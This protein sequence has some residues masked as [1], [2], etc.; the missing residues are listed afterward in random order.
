M[1]RFLGY[2]RRRWLCH[3]QEY[4]QK[5]SS[6]TNSW[7]GHDTMN[8]V[9]DIDLRLPAACLHSYHEAFSLSAKPK[10]IIITVIIC[11]L[12]HKATRYEWTR[13]KDTRSL[14][15]PHL[16]SIISAFWWELIG[17]RINMIAYD[18]YLFVVT[19]SQEN[20]IFTQATG[21]VWLD[22]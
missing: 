1:T 16:L 6:V 5:T 13:V 20:A 19:P 17:F 14:F 18:Y 3:L 8:Q 10:P 21:L 9:R 11:H 15:P 12:S 7:V 2:Y 22:F 4:I